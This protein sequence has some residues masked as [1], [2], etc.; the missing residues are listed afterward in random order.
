MGHR[1]KVTLQKPG[2]QAVPPAETEEVKAETEVAETEVAETEV[3]ETE[4]KAETEEVKAETTPEEGGEN[5]PEPQDDVELAIS[6]IPDEELRQKAFA[7]YQKTKQEAVRNKAAKAF[8]AFD[9]ECKTA[10]PELILQL[11]KKHSADLTGR[12]LII[13]FPSLDK[14]L[15]SNIVAKGGNGSGRSGGRSGNGFGKVFTSDTGEK[16]AYQSV[17]FQGET[18]SSLNALATAK[19][20]KYNGRA[21]GTQ[22]VTVLQDKDG[23]DIGKNKVELKDGVVVVSEA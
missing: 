6:Q 13:T 7:S 12:K 3:V 8:V 15:F 1:H 11:A 9:T 10:V 19:G 16:L 2:K 4:V 21:N 14:P 17:S 22:A 20:W 23:K 18:F 5:E